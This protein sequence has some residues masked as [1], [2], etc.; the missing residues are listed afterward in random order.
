[1]AASLA[2]GAS[3]DSQGV[4]GSS[5]PGARPDLYPE[6]VSRGVAYN[7]AA[8]ST[9]IVGGVLVV[10]GASLLVAAGVQRERARSSRVALRPAAGGLEL[11][12]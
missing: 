11:R 2:L 3:L 5:R 9:G 8:L 1:M 12:F 10:A 7:R 6:L 4:E